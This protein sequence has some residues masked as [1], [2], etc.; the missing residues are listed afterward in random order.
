MLQRSDGAPDNPINDL[1]TVVLCTVRCATGQ[2]GAHTDREGW[3]LPHEAPTAPRTLRA[4]KG[5]L[6]A[7]EQ[8]TKHS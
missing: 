7:M 5:P 4:I 1:L 2:T 8:Y 3:M 6:G